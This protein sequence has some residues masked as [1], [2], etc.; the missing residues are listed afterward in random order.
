MAGSVARSRLYGN[1]KPGL[2]R[3]RFPRGSATQVDGGYLLTFMTELHTYG[4]PGDLV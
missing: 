3:R 4:A 2:E 1:E